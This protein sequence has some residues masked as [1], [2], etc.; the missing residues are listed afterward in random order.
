M[1]KEQKYVKF[2]KKE[3]EEIIVK[4]NK[5]ISILEEDS[6]YIGTKSLDEKIK[7]IGIRMIHE[8]NHANRLL[9]KFR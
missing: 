3:L 1:K 5:I 8:V 7:K 4:L 6:Y 9:E 2:N